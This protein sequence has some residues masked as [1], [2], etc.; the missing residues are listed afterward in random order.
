MKKNGGPAYPLDVNKEVDGY[1][2]EGMSLRDYFAAAALTGYLASFSG[3][4]CRTPDAS[5]AA[6]KAYEFA[7]AMLEAGE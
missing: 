3:P 1:T 4:D 6:K 2:N 7:D 5:E